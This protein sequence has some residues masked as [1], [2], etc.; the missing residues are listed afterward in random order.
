MPRTCDDSIPDNE[1]TVAE[2]S[3]MQPLACKSGNITLSHIAEAP[4]FQRVAAN[5]K[6]TFQA[7]LIFRV[8]I[9]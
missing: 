8:F 3:F 4:N 5:Y 2:S 1:Q 7:K 6:W 9:T